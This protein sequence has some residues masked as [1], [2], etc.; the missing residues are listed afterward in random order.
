MCRYTIVAIFPSLCNLLEQHLISRLCNV[1]FVNEKGLVRM[2]IDDALLEFDKS[3]LERVFNKLHDDYKCG[4]PD[5]YK[6][7]EYLKK[8]LKDLY[9]NSYVVIIELIKKKLQKYASEKSI[10]KFLMAISS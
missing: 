9:G 10:E 6:N 5:C 2:A 8:V 3:A 4:I 1:N 7:P